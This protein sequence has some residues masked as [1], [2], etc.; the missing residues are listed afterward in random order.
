M[1]V[2]PLGRLLRPG[3]T[4]LVGTGT[5]EPLALIEALITAATELGQAARVRVIQ[6]MTGGTER[7]AEASGGALR[8]ATPVPGPKTRKAIAEGRV[9]LLS[10]PMSGLLRGIVSGSLRIDGV[11]LQGRALDRRHAT[12]GLIAD[13][14]IPAWEK[15]RFRALELN[16]C[17]PRIACDTPIEIATADHVVHSSREPNELHE[18]PV[19]GEAARIGAF[20]TELV[21]DG[22]TIELGVGRALAGVVPALIKRRRNLAMHTGIVGNAAMRLIQ[23]GCVTRR[24]RGT[25]MAVGATAMGTHAYYA[26]ADDN[27]H[28]ALVDS[29]LAH[30]SDHLAALPS[31]VAINAALQVDLQ[32]NVNSTSHKGRVVSGV[33]GAGD[34]AQAGAR[35][36]AS[37][38]ALCSTRPDGSSTLVPL[39]DAI[40]VPGRHVTHVVTEYGI[41][42][43]RD[44]WGSERGRASIALIAAQ[45]H[46]AALMG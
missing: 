26:W 3:D 24:V 1:Q 5:G 37:I 42:C 19:S 33:G 15:A 22:A 23:A 2:N 28:I 31:F 41:A 4:I 43:L 11:L 10:E 14:M 35:G 9:D 20:I 16:N 6:V 21:P 18:D 45:Q 8:V 36:T 27:P 38:I 29:R 46:R 30:N 25:A 13:I 34:F 44:E 17:L 40:S 32:G 7:L 39:V 12:P